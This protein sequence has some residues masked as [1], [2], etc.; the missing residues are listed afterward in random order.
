MILS[1]TDATG[2]GL[3]ESSIGLAFLFGSI[4]FTAIIRLASR[5]LKVAIYCGLLGGL[6]S[7]FRIN[8]AKYFSYYVF[9]VSLVA[10]VEQCNT[11]FLQEHG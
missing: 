8:K 6:K 2:L 7:N 10:L 3:V 1:F 9:M 11:Q 5:E 4:T